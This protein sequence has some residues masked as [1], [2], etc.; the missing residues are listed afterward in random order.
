MKDM[1]NS[2]KIL[3]LFTAF[4]FCFV[5]YSHGQFIQHPPEPMAS[6]MDSQQVPGQDCADDYEGTTPPPGL[7]MPI[8]DYI[9]P[10]LIAGIFLGAYQVQRI[11]AAK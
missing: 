6:D 9:I 4:C 3:F 8:N 11:E 5:L 2:V 10:L 7:C 1:K